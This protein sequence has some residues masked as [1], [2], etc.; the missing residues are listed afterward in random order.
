MSKQQIL[1]RVKKN[2]RDISGNL[3]NTVFEE[4]TIVKI[5]TLYSKK[6]TELSD[7][8][9]FVTALYKAG[10]KQW[11]NFVTKESTKKLK[12]ILMKERGYK[13]QVYEVNEIP[14]RVLKLQFSGF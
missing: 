12:K 5:L 7:G 4:L 6:V 9:I 10:D 8:M 13:T 2:E 1:D 14:V 3:S 11:D